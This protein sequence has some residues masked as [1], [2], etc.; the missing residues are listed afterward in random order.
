MAED[1]RIVINGYIADKFYGCNFNKQNPDTS[2]TKLCNDLLEKIIN[3][4][5]IFLEDKNL[6]R[7]KECAAAM[8]T[9]TSFIANALLS[10]IDPEPDIEPEK[11]KMKVTTTKQNVKLKIKQNSITNWP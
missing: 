4:E 9:T 1:K 5:I 10:R 2:L 11:I 7:Y 3:D 8:N 6:A